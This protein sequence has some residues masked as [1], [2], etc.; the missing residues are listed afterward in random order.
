MFA[1]VDLIDRNVIL[2]K[3]KVFVNALVN[4]FSGENLLTDLKYNLSQTLPFK[5]YLKARINFFDYKPPQAVS[6]IRSQ[7]TYS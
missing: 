5:L 7:S 2:N 3:Y 4:K 1:N 6:S